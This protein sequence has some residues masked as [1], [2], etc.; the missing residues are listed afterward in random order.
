MNNGGKSL[1]LFCLALLALLGILANSIFGWHGGVTD[2]NA[3]LLTLGFLKDITIS[4]V[5]FLAGSSSPDLP[6]HFP[7][8]PPPEPPHG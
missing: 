1:A 5:G 6:K 4:V 3:Q 2:P 7:V 8:P